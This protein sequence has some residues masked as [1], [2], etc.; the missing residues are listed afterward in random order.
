VV[1]PNATRLLTGMTL[2]YLTEV[3]TYLTFTCIIHLYL[4][5]W[6]LFIDASRL[7]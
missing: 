6:F 1:Y 4:Y 5:A 3:L 2:K 7:V